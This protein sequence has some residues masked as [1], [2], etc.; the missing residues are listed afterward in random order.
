MP[1]CLACKMLKNKPKLDKF[2]QGLIKKEDISYKQSLSL[3]EAMHREA[4]LL[5]VINAKN[6]LEGLEAD[7]R[8]AR[9]LNGLS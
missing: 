5:G 7:M 4:V 8:I 9:A 1:P 2:Y 3:F 6:M